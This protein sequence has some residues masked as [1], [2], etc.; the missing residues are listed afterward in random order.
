MLRG[1]TVDLSDVL[2]GAQATPGLRLGD[3]ID[4]VGWSTPRRGRLR[5]FL[6]CSSEP[7]PRP[8]QVAVRR[9]GLDPI[10]T[11]AS[12]PLDACY[13]GSLHLAEVA[14]PAGDGPVRVEIGTGGKRWSPRAGV[15]I[16]VPQEGLP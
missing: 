8:V 9:A 10:R 16:A 5:L 14:L 2:E 6:R 15:D 13:P 11:A 7:G 4:L 1:E 3:A 12:P